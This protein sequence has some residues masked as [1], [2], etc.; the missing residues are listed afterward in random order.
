[1]YIPRGYCYIMIIMIKTRSIK[2]GLRELICHIHIHQVCDP[3]VHNFIMFFFYISYNGN[4]I[5]VNGTLVIMCTL[6][7]S[8]RIYLHDID[9]PAP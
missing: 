9:D 5:E 2:R 3:L 1:M 4:D 8:F 7:F 6:S